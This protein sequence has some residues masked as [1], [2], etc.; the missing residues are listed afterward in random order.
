[1][2]T[3]QGL[4]VILVGITL[5]LSGCSS[6]KGDDSSL[7]ADLSLQPVFPFSEPIVVGDPETNPADAYLVTSDT[8]KVFVSWTAERSDGQGR[9]VLIASVSRDE[10]LAEI[11]QMNQEPISGHGSERRT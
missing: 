1:M 4:L 8:G 2:K 5:A 7:T 11:R 3:N 9:N 10:Q 6:T